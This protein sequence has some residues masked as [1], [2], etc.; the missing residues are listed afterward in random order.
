[1][2]IAVTAGNVTALSPEHS[3]LD[4]PEVSYGKS[5]PKILLKNLYQQSAYTEYVLN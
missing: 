5:V 3:I 4:A 2:L 1:M